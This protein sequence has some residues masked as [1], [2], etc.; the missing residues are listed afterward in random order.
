MAQLNDTLV[1]GDL[2]VTG[3]M[4]GTQSATVVSNANLAVPPIST[5]SNTS[6]VGDY[7]VYYGANKYLP[8]STNNYS[9]HT[10]AT[11]FGSSMYRATQIATA[12]SSDKP[13]LLYERSAVSS[14]GVAWTFG[15]WKGVSFTDHTHGNIGNGGTLTDTAAAAAGN[16]YVV[17]R[18]A[19]NSKIQ[20]STIKG[21]DVADAVSKTHSHSSLT[22]STTPA[23]YDGS[24]TLALPS[25]DP[26]SSAR[27]PTAHAVS[28]DTYGKSTSSN[29]GHVKLSDAIDGT[30]AAAS[31]GT[32]AT[33]KAVSDGL[34]SVVKSI[35]WD[36]TAATNNT[37]T[38]TVGSNT[39]T[40]AK[41][42]DISKSIYVTCSTAAATAGKEAAYA[43]Y[44]DT[45]QVSGVTVRVKFANANTVASPTFKLGSGTA[46]PIYKYGSTAAGKDA[47]TS[48]SAGAVV[49][50]TYDATANSNAGGWI[51]ADHIDNTNTT[52]NGYVN[53]YCST[54]ATTAAKVADA[55]NY[56][57]M[58]VGNVILVTFTVKSTVAGALTLNVNGKGAKP[59]KV[60]GVLTA[61]GSTTEIPIGTWP[62]YYDG[63][64][65]NIWTTGAYQFQ[66]IYAK[67]IA[68][69]NAISVGSTSPT[70]TE[71]RD[72][73]WNGQVTT[74]YARTLIG[75]S[76]EVLYMPLLHMPNSSTMDI[77]TIGFGT[78]HNGIFFY[79]TYST[80]NVW[81]SGSMSLESYVETGTD[82]KKTTDSGVA[83]I[84]V[85]TSGFDKGTE[86]FVEGT[87]TTALGES[88]HAEGAITSAAP[89]FGTATVNTA[90]SENAKTVKLTVASGG[91]ITANK[92]CIY[93]PTYRHSSL[94]TAFSNSTAT[95]ESP[96]ASALPVN[97]SVIFVTYANNNSTTVSGSIG[98]ATH[99][100]GIDT[101]AIANASH[102]EGTGTITKGYNSHAEGYKSKADGINSHAEG[103]NTQSIGID[104]HAEGGEGT[105]IGDHS[106]AEGWA[107]D[108]QGV[109]SHAEG[110]LCLAAGTSSHA[111]G[112]ATCAV[113]KDSHAEGFGDTINFVK[114]T[115]SSNHSS[116]A[117]WSI[118]ATGNSIAVGDY[119]VVLTTSDPNYL[120][121][122]V[123]T[124]T[125]K[126][127]S[128]ASI[129]T[130]ESY[131][132][133][134]EAGRPV[135]FTRAGAVGE[136]SHA[137]GDESLSVGHGSHAEGYSSKAIGDYSHAEGYSS[138]AS[139]QYSHA[140]GYSSEASGMHSH[141]EGHQSFAIGP[142]S[143]SENSGIAIG[144]YSH[145]EGSSYGGYYTG[146]T[147]YRTHNSTNGYN[148]W[149]VSNTPVEITSGG[150][151]YISVV[152]NDVFKFS[153]R[154]SSVDRDSSSGNAEIITTTSYEAEVTG[155]GTICSFFNT[156]AV[157]AFSHTEG[158]NCIA[159][160][161]DSHAE[162]SACKALHDYSHAEGGNTEATGA[163]A[164]A[165]GNTTKA[166]EAYSHA[167]GNSC[168]ANGAGSHAEGFYS[169]ANGDFS[170][171]EGYYTI[172]DSDF[173]HAA[174]KLNSTTSGLARVTGWGTNDNNKIDIERL[175]TAGNLWLNG[176]CE[177]Q[178]EMKVHTSSNSGSYDLSFVV[179]R[180]NSRKVS[181]CASENAHGVYDDTNSI[182]QSFNPNR[183]DWHGSIFDVLFGLTSGFIGDAGFDRVYGN[184]NSSSSSLCG[185][186]GFFNIDFND[187]PIQNMNYDAFKRTGLY[188]IF[189]SP[190]AGTKYSPENGAMGLLVF[191][192]NNNSD[193]SKCFIVQIAFGNYIYHRSRGT[194]GFGSWKKVTSTNL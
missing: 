131:A 41:A 23:A 72:K 77:G 113:G 28:T 105:A 35:A 27:T 61:S 47:N 104:S 88:A 51:M 65:W 189:N 193:E 25:T 60:N 79:A 115:L 165:E 183:S 179:Q 135:V 120:Y 107:G 114:T 89:T 110:S 169:K 19:D 176:T 108:A 194:T 121:R 125:V 34:A 140:E 153:G 43:G 185:G 95:L 10:V 128:G 52:Y 12:S 9:I 13:S 133:T 148:K 143:H 74:Y 149:E 186:F 177:A 90:A 3:T 44:T 182:W 66:K 158:N 154:I 1:Q 178:G 173:M 164:H 42:S 7:S 188:R 56:N 58:S 156:G 174:G 111:E 57:T 76:S 134:V 147:L 152:Q 139:G 24:H 78:F 20:T 11:N 54:A 190:A 26:Y 83:T 96:C 63:T 92:T 136:A 62:C 99:T 46:K 172:A 159:S 171:A 71:L 142:Y 15:N 175:S 116:G 109:S 129:T 40:K 17:I 155:T 64:N 168:E 117:N 29:Y 106:H 75:A 85:N 50:L 4:Y 39:T 150:P 53:A 145:A 170:H 2:R 124:G 118:V 146:Y 100:E 119:M 184:S 93:I 32:A 6:T 163:Y 45:E 18:D 49:T 86:S 161:T 187:P 84:S 191:S 8:D 181:L 48:W 160:G 123:F 157:G 132:S 162:G 102:A 97:T 22:L 130:N 91:T 138:K 101:L 36:T 67:D 55:R 21:T 14:D 87:R 81:N 31:G 16:D 166:S 38:Q 192:V 144:A 80:G 68:T 112:G 94:V 126:S 122:P 127:I 73:L 151:W 70:Y 69:D 141:A 137:E 37:L 98:N 103:S 30:S 59:I 167:E 180:G 5:T 33:P 82:L